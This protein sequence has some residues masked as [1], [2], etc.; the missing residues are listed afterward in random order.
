[1]RIIAGSKFQTPRSG[2]AVG[3]NAMRGLQKRRRIVGLAQLHNTEH[4]NP[5]DRAARRMRGCHVIRAGGLGSIRNWGGYLASTCRSRALQPTQRRHRPI[6]GVSDF[7][8]V[9][10][11]SMRRCRPLLEGG[12]VIPFGNYGNYKVD[13]L[14]SL[15]EKRAE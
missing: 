1:M 15:S 12:D 11:S 14:S 6:L 5:P 3:G 2:A 4:R 10:R 7:A 9:R 13:Y 8:L